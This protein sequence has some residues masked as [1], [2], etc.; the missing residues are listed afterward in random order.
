MYFQGNFL[1]S[2]QNFS[3]PPVKCLPVR[4]WVLLNK[5]FK[6][7]GKHISKYKSDMVIFSTLSCGC[8]WPSLRKAK[9]KYFVA[10]LKV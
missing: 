5:N 8:Q 6:Y 1:F 9:M 10:Q 4:L 3:A 7:T 2:G